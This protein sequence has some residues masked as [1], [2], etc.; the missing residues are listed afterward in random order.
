MSLPNP[1]LPR[2]TVLAGAVASVLAA[3]AVRAQTFRSVT[4]RHVGHGSSWLGDITR[5]ASEDLGFKI[6]ATPLDATALAQRG[7]TQPGSFD[8]IELDNWMIRLA[9]PGGSLQAFDVSKVALF[10]QVVPIFTKGRLNDQAPVA[11]GTSPNTIMFTEGADARRFS[12]DPT[13]WATFVPG[14]YNA[15]T[16]GI[17][18]DLVGKPIDSW[19]SLLD[20]AFRGRT[21]LINV[22]S[23]G[24][25]DAAFALEASGRVRYAD[26]GNMTK[27]EIDATINALIELKKQGQFRA[28]WGNF[29]Q[30]V[31]LMTSGEVVIQSMWSAAVSVVRS[32]GL[33][34][35][36]VPLK[37]G[38]RA[39][40]TGL[41]MSRNLDG[42][43]REAAYAYIN[44]WLSGWAGAF[45]LRQ[46]YYPSVLETTRKLVTPE[47]W[48]FW[49]EGKPASAAILNP[50]GETMEP[51]GAVRDGGSFADRMGKVACWNSVMD[52]NAYMVSRWTEFVAS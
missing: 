14:M 41:A 4:L 50:F 12:R 51:Q 22:P 23:I 40:C 32:R 48:A 2:R 13:P 10:D 52:E 5:K 38:Y 25:I 43:E 31:A 36:Y 39:W 19:A 49:M 45:Y 6:E 3:P 29:E 27:A 33:A 11:Q 9:A 1:Q 28:F 30:S 16:L 35:Q 20:P 26:K 46:G 17:R 8:V 18:P 34:C 42:I 47:E 21:A 24:I 15:D 7:R 44:W 37:E